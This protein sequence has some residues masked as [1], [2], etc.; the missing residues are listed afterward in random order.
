MLLRLRRAALGSSRL[1]PSRP[2]HSAL[3]IGVPLAQTELLQ[4]RALWV[5]CWAGQETRGQGLLLRAAKSAIR[6]GAEK[7]GQAAGVRVGCWSHL[8]PDCSLPPLRMT[9]VG[10]WGADLVSGLWAAQ[11]GGLGG[12]GLSLQGVQDPVFL[13]LDDVL[14]GIPG[15]A[16]GGSRGH[17]SAGQWPLG[18]GGPILPSP[19]PPGGGQ[20]PPGVPVSRTRV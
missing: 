6:R 8:H 4:I 15:A 3:H 17:L 1:G 9:P 12:H 14:Q 16:A 11:E 7:R 18:G 10:P 13:K 20:S 19:W 2:R 5:S